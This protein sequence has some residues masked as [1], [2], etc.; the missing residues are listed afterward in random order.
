MSINDDL[1]TIIM[2]SYNTVPYYRDIFDNNNID[3]TSI[4][5]ADDL[6]RLPVLDK[7]IIKRDQQ[8]FFSSAFNFKND[9]NNE[10]KVERTTGTTGVP[11][12]V[13]WSRVDLTS[14]LFH[15]WRYRSHHFGIDASHRFCSFHYQ[16]KQENPEIQYN[17]NK[18]DISYN[19]RYLSEETLE[20]YYEHMCFCKPDWLY[21]QPSVAYIL[22]SYISENN[23]ELP[24]SIR[25]IELIGEP[26]FNK[27]RQFID[28]FFSL[29]TSNMYGCVETNGI[30]Y[31]CRN[32]K[33]HLLSNNVIVE[34]LDKD[35]MPVGYGEE[36]DICLTGLCN[37]AM[38]IVRY[39]PGD[40]G[41]LFPGEV[42]G[43]GNCNPVLE[44]VGGRLGEFIFTG[45]SGGYKSS[46]IIY[47]IQKIPLKAS[48]GG[49][50]FKFQLIRNTGTSYKVIFERNTRKNWNEE[51]L[52][53]RFV[54]EMNSLDLHNF[55]WDFEFV[56]AF[57]FKTLVGTLVY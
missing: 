34:V 26:A 14:S 5:C 18:R 45:K 55:T 22:A 3:P 42:C 27:Y 48:I 21:I 50:F 57:S 37:T 38:P 53:S 1:K 6:K 28:E 30:A 7:E 12:K 31:E 51:N 36:G 9:I 39:L 2:H 13:Y 20:I 29:P 54:D 10:L 11:F 24:S 43:C 25:Y 32:R 19:K 35:N 47:P 49:N 16:S 56:E 8:V 23:L 52:K 4:K 33:F 17:D 40:R 44:L 15:H 46:N 41:K